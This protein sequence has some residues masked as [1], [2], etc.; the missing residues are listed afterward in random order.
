MIINLIIAIVIVTIITNFQT[1]IA[2]I[3]IINV[4]IANELILSLTIEFQT[5][6][7]FLKYEFIK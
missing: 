5:V 6:K 2:S 7:L 3:I 4:W 1:V